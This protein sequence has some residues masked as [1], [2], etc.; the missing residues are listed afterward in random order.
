MPVL[1][2]LTTG[3]L[4]D[5]I[6]TVYRKNFLL[7]FSIAL[8]P[9]VCYLIT[10]GV[11]T[12]VLGRSPSVSGVVAMVITMLVGI[13]IYIG[14]MGLSQGAT[15]VAVSDLYLDKPASAMEAFRHTW[16]IKWRL[17]GLI[18]GYGLLVVLGIILLIIP[19]VYWLVTYALATAVMANERVSFS[20]AMSR[21]KDLVAGNRG[22]IAIILL[23]SFVI[24]YAVAFGIGIPVQLGVVALARTIPVAA[25]LLGM[26]VQLVAAAVAAP[27]SL[28]GFTLAYYDARVRKEAFDLHY[29]MESEG[30]AAAA[31]STGA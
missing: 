7:F 4:L 16:P 9:Q 26:A 8:V 22:R 21:S 5:R 15:V 1:Q 6:F 13:V 20:E 18:I 31:A 29:M 28:I 23:L 12:A 24:S 30:A 17:V 25:T 27:I 3:Q 10:F 2:A 11:P 19:G 14:A